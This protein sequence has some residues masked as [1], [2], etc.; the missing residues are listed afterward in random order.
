M[1]EMQPGDVRN[2]W[3]DTSLMKEITGFEP[4]TPISEGVDKF[5]NWYKSYHQL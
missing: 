1:L 4:N 3:A 5:V 2:T